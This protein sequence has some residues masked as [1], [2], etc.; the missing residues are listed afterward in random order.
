MKV[1][2]P[3]SLTSIILQ[4]EC[5]ILGFECLYLYLEGQYSLPGLYDLYLDVVL[6][7]DAVAPDLQMDLAL[8][9]RISVHRRQVKPAFNTWKKITS[10]WLNPHAAGS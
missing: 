7:V 2:V 3:L 8:N 10:I 9:L 1:N 6:L 5:S 4:R